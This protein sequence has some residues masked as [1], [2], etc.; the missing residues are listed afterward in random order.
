LVPASYLA[1]G[2][3][4]RYY[5]FTENEE[6]G[7]GSFRSDDMKIEEGKYYRTRGGHVFG[8]MVWDKDHT[9]NYP[10]H[11]V[12]TEP[13][14]CWDK[15]G[16]WLVAGTSQLD[17][18]SEVYVSD[19]PPADALAILAICAAIVALAVLGVMI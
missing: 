17:L 5:R 11:I 9:T 4:H 6:M 14:V 2:G 3:H 8:P 10:W 19:T 15:R 13:E 7:D 18:A 12:S 16:F 1:C